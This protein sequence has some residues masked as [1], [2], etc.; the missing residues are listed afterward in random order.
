MK[1]QTDGESHD[2]QTFLAPWINKFSKERG[3]AHAPSALHLYNLIP[4]YYQGQL[5]EHLQKN[6]LK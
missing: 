1:G 5:G 2:N 4:K 3:T 6:T